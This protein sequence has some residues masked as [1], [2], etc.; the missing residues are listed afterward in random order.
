MDASHWFAIVGPAHENH[1]CHQELSGPVVVG[2]LHLKPAGTL[3]ETVPQWTPPQ[4][5][6][7]ELR[8]SYPISVSAEVIPAVWSSVE[9]PWKG[10]LAPNVSAEA[11]TLLH[12]LRGL[13]AIAWDRNWTVRGLPAPE[14]YALPAWIGGPPSPELGREAERGE[15]LE[16]VPV[17]IPGWMDHAWALLDDDRAL[18][19][20]VAIH[21][22]GVALHDRHPSVALLAYVAAIESIGQSMD[23]PK[24]CPVCRQILG[25]TSAFRQA[26]GEVMSDDEAAALGF[27]KLRGSTV[28]SGVLHGNEGLLGALRDWGEEEDPRH[29]FGYEVVGRLRRASRELIGKHLGTE[30][31]PEM[32][33]RVVY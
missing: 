29:R 20:S 13:L 22:E 24:R 31:L 27:P 11:A 15:Q 12:R 32:L 23:Q 6:G 2:P 30:D 14:S 21:L 4:L 17:D 7:V 3:R 8:W 33:Q 5:G 10:F 19:N 18:E 28:H 26:L 1:T 16:A 9:R 25:A